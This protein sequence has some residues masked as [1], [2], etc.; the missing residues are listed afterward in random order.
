MIHSK[1]KIQ[2]G[3][4]YWNATKGLNLSESD[5]SVSYTKYINNY[6]NAT[7]DAQPND[8]TIDN[9]VQDGLTP[10]K[11]PKSEIKSNFV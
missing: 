6:K 11:K 4:N 2:F 1:E 3:S 9:A 10:G 5:V 7:K 8:K